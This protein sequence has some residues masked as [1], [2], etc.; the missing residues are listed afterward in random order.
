[1]LGILLMAAGV[2]FLAAPDRITEFLAI[3]VGAVITV[4]SIFRLIMVFVNWK[5]M[6]NR[7]LFLISG[8][9]TLFIGIF[10][11]L[12]PDVTIT[13]IG[14]IIGVFAILLAVDRF[15]TANRLKREINILPTVISGLVHLVFGIAMVYS[16]LVVFTV[17]IVLTGV[18]LL[19]AGLMFTLS[20]LFF[21]DF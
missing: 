8:I 7:F 18:Y 3:L 4:F 15:I 2:I 21:H 5:T 1:M 16:A 13:I 14:A 17:I 20:A 6:I 19:I 10:M 9:I 12:N 11:L